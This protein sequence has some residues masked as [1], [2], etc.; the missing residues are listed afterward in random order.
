MPRPL[1]FALLCFAVLL[2]AG[3]SSS[4]EPS[5]DDDSVQPS[6]D[7]DTADDDDTGDDDDSGVEITLSGQVT[8]SIEPALDGI[9]TLRV[10]VLASPPPNSEVTAVFELKNADLS[11]SDSAISYEITGIPVRDEPYQ[12]SAGLDDDGDG[13]RPDENDMRMSPRA[14]VTLDQDVGQITLDLVLNEHGNSA[15]PGDDDD[16]AGD[17]DDSAA[18]GLPAGDQSCSTD[19]DCASGICWDFSH[20]ASTCGGT[21]CSVTCTS[22][23]DCVLFFTPL[24][25]NNP[26]S[27]V[28]GSDYRCDPLSAQAGGFWCQ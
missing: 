2:T 12:I 17:D 8:R 5:D 10:R 20:Y 13:G 16:S 19:S 6:D 28:C 7:D 26:N 22:D 25:A 11:A 23:A 21:M 1:L 18:P 27:A 3:C 4:P 24:G 9:G 15:I 14:E